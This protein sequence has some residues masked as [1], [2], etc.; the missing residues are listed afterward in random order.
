MWTSSILIIIATFAGLLTLWRDEIVDVKVTIPVDETDKEKTKRLS[1]ELKKEKTKRIKTISTIFI[2]LTLLFT[3]Y[4]IHLSNVAANKADYEKQQ[5][6]R[7]DSDKYT[8]DSL[9][10]LLERHQDNIAYLQLDSTYRNSIENGK[11]VNNIRK[12]S[13]SILDSLDNVRAKIEAYSNQ[14]INSLRKITL[15]SHDLL[16]QIPDHVLV[17]WGG[18]F[19]V[20]DFVAKTWNEELKSSTIPNQFSNFSLNEKFLFKTNS[21]LDAFNPFTNLFVELNYN[22][23]NVRFSGNF[24][25]YYL[26]VDRDNFSD[27]TTEYV[28]ILYDSLNHKVKFE[29]N[30]KLKIDKVSGTVSSLKSIS[31]CDVIFRSA[32]TG[33]YTHEKGSKITF[34]ILLSNKYK[35]GGYDILYDSKKMGYKVH[36]NNLLEAIEYKFE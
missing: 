21:P 1:G 8:K 22:K 28:N 6:H 27:N 13:E 36:V 18:E 34:W 10:H 3:L 9:Q 23:Q 17:V 5:Q 16:T 4:Q 33:I 14:Q 26:P 29:G 30:A 7:A 19:N 11:A 12:S 31:K 2:F 35:A 24:K 15:Q 32:F 25:N 20:D